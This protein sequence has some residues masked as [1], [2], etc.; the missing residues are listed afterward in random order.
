MNV[1]ELVRSDLLNIK[2]PVHGGLGWKYQGVEDFSSN[3]NPLGPPPQVRDYMLQA[4]DR[5]I[6]YPDDGGVELKDAISRR[7]GVNKDN[8]MLGAGSAEL[9][10]LFP[11]VF[12]NKG[13]GVIMPR[14]T[15]A[16][17]QFAPE[18]EG[19]QHPRFPA[20]RDRWVP[21]RLRPAEL[22]DR[23][24]FQGGLHLQPEQSDRGGGEPEAHRG[25]HRRVR[26]TEHPGLPGRDAAGACGQRPRF[27]LHRGGEGH[28]NRSSYVRSPSASPFPGCGWVTPSVRRTSSA[29][30]TT[31]AWHRTGPGGDARCRPFAGCYYGHIETAARL[32]AEEKSYRSMPSRRPRWSPHRG[33]TRSSSSIGSTA[34]WI[35]SS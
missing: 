1:E 25:D 15:F 5:L 22:H 29:T 20:V 33:R 24:R 12:I 35:P 18:D 26:E 19:C 21:F 10:R 3:L 16:E 6:Y 17:Y 31:P 14:P 23:V 9:I 34:A 30:W 27:D 4:A 2:R 28:E 32:M 7:F 8:I 13:D 11:D